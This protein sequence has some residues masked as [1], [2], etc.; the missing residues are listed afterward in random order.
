MD[1]GD[2]WKEWVGKVVV[3]DT[4]SSFVYL[5][6]LAEVRKDRILLQQVDVHDRHE[7]QTS[8][9]QYVLSARKFGV[10]PGRKSAMVMADKIVSLSLLDDVIEY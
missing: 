4:D 1:S 8:N 9:E 3:V 10:R 5:G 7:G 6:T 2:G